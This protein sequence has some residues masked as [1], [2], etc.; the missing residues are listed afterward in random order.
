M[1]GRERREGKEKRK[2]PDAMG[3]EEIWRG[4]TWSLSPDVFLRNILRAPAFIHIL[5]TQDDILIVLIIV[6]ILITIII[7]DI[8][9]IIFI[10]I[11]ILCFTIIIFHIII[12]GITLV[13]TIIINVIFIY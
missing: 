13:I 4:G 10:Y 3:G 6:I 11:F 7:I 5:Y 12:I 8:I 9:N 2:E 1:G